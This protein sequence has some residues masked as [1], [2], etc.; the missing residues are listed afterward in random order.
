MISLNGCSSGALFSPRSSPSLASSLNPGGFSWL[1]FFSPFRLSQQSTFRCWPWPRCFSS[2]ICMPPALG[3]LF[4][5]LHLS[6]A[7][8]APEAA[9]M[10]LLVVN[11]PCSFAHFFGRPKSPIGYF[12]FAISRVQFPTLVIWTSLRWRKGVRYSFGRTFRIPER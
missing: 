12:P 11:A 2:R 10:Q 9:L 4:R 5:V 7:K 3:Y 8:F 1:L 6:S